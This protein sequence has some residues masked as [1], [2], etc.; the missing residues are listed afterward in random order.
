M[1]Y[2]KQKLTPELQQKLDQ[3]IKDRNEAFLSKDRAKILEY[4]R[5][6]NVPVPRSEESF[7]I[8]VHKVI[9]HLENIDTKQRDDA[10]EWLESRGYSTDL[11]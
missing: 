5:K 11:K 10:V 1:S 9:A 3:F 2:D 7:W 4:C 6:Y 8:M